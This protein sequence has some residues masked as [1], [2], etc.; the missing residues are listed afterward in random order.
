MAKQHPIHRSRMTAACGKLQRF[1]ASLEPYF[2]IINIFIQAKPEYAA[3]VWVGANDFPGLRS[4]VSF[5][6]QLIWQPFDHQF[7]GLLRRLE[8][9]KT[10]FHYEVSV[11]TTEE[12]I[13]FYSKYEANMLEAER[14]AGSDNHYNAIEDER[15]KQLRMWIN[16][17]TWMDKFE[18]AQKHRTAGT[19][20]YILDNQIYLDWKNKIDNSAVKFP[21]KTLSIRSSETG[22][23]K[24]VLCATTIDDLIQGEYDVYFRRAPRDPAT[25]VAFYF[26]DSRR[27]VS[28]RLVD[29]GRALLAQ[30]IHLH[31][32]KMDFVDI[33]STVFAKNVTG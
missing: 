30:L 20:D 17:P 25:T 28:N 14:Q 27:V 11:I 4:K 19:T 33:A 23:R 12:A 22:L 13:T 29:A 5:I 3:L 31:Q 10:L 7:E 8:E 1:A 9:H 6:R 21:S 2:D 26:F 24:T 16:P 15:V 18:Q 32:Y